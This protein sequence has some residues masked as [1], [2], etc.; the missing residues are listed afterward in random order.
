MRGAKMKRSAG[1]ERGIEGKRGEKNPQNDRV[2]DKDCGNEEIGHK[3]AQRAGQEMISE[4]N[5]TLR[6]KEIA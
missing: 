6:G 4:Q 3:T 5:D 1:K 2:R